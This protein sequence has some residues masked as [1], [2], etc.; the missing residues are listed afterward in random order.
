MQRP[1][2][3]CINIFAQ[4]RSAETMASLCGDK[5]THTHLRLQMIPL[6]IFAVALSVSA[7]QLDPQ[8]NQIGCGKLESTGRVYKGEPISRERIPWIVQMSIQ[9]NSVY[10][11]MCSGSI[12]T[13]NVILTASHCLTYKGAFPKNVLVLHNNTATLH[14][15]AVTADRIQ[16]H[17]RFV[18]N[19]EM[20]YD[21]ALLKLSQDI[22]F[23]TTMKPVCL[24]TSDIDVAGKTLQVAG[25]GRTES[26]YSSDVL[27]HGRVSG[28]ADDECQTWLMQIINPLTQQPVKPGPMICVTGL[29]AVTCKGD[30]G[31]P[32]ILENDHGRSTQVGICSAGVDCSLNYPTYFTRVA[33]HMQWIKEQLGKPR[34]WRRIQSD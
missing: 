25:W 31:G 16:L 34:E 6:G 23:T 21:V 32:L 20:V 27:R 5:V 22:R 19:G 17:R 14:G 33:F 15:L 4:L 30:S 13:R 1:F 3:N 8:I 2:L 12:I 24:P 9:Y 7:N 28:M 10:Q 18:N 11:Y 29:S 26:G